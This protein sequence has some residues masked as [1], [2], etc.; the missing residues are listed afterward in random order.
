MGNELNTE[1]VKPKSAMSEMVISRQ[2]QE[3]QGAMVIARKFPRDENIAY[4]KIMRSCARISL[5]EVAEYTYPR[6]GEKISGPSIRLAETIA[7]NWGNIDYGV[8]EL[9]NAGGKSELMAYAWDLESNTRI[10]KIF[11]VKHRRDTKK[12]SYDLT[13]SR[14]IYEATANFGAR[15]VRACILGIIPGDIIESAVKECR[16]TIKGENKSPIEDR[17]RNMLNT[18]L[19]DHRVTQEQIEKYLGCSVKAINEQELIRMR[20]VNQ[21]IT[22][23]M[24]KSADYFEIKDDKPKV[25]DP[26]KE[27]PTPAAPVSTE[28]PDKELRAA[29]KKKYPKD[30]D[31]QIDA[32]IAESR[33]K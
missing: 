20:G 15:R 17:I 6:G 16:K 25:E 5:A 12:G 31:W 13:D 22:D 8:I 28:D 1:V 4:S 7:Q 26:L 2:A 33:A 9:E 24:S 14:D 18:F 19:K 21:S 32:R 11:S 27:T 3:V 29:L 10:T 23:G 30:E